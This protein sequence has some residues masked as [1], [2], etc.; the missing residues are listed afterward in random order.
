M[1]IS[2]NDIRQKVVNHSFETRTAEVI[3]ETLSPGDCR[4]LQASLRICSKRSIGSDGHP[5]PSQPPR[6]DPLSESRYIWRICRAVLGWRGIGGILH[7][8]SKKG[9]KNQKPFAACGKES[10]SRWWCES[11]VHRLHTDQM[12]VNL[13]QGDKFSTKVPGMTKKN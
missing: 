10:S 9:E 8:G 7:M 12:I 5:S 2:L 6:E 13:R 4:D 11:S 1:T 3:K